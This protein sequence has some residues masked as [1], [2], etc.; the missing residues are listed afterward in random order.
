MRDSLGIT[1]SVVGS[2]I[3]RV[4]VIVESSVGITELTG[5]S[6]IIVSAG[7]SAEGCEGGGDGER[8]DEMKVESLVCVRMWQPPG[9]SV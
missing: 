8:V 6:G 4:T 7:V 9:C 1:E 3:V 2:G 5:D